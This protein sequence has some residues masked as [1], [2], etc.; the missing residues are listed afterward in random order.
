MKSL[1][2]LI[3]F[4]V[5][6]AA[7]LALFYASNVSKRETRVLGWANSLVWERLGM[8]HD[9]K[10]S[11]VS[12]ARDEERPELWT[13]SGQL[14]KEGGRPIESYTAVIERI[15]SSAERRCWRLAELEIAGTRMDVGAARA[16]ADVGPPRDDAADQRPAAPPAAATNGGAPEGPSSA[17]K[18]AGEAH[19][20]GAT[21]AVQAPAGA[22]ADEEGLSGSPLSSGWGDLRPYPLEAQLPAPPLPRRRP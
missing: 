20:A 1:L 12:V 3:F 17:V 16:A 13:I 9:V 2:F 4:S 6:V 11:A 19:E 18:A 5:S 14:E 7:G 15:C 21:L 22:A 8:P 10:F